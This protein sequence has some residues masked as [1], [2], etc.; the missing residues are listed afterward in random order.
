[1]LALN[2]FNKGRVLQVALGGGEPTLHPA[3]PL[4][5]KETYDRGIV[6]NLTTNGKKMLPRVI[7]AIS[8]YCGA[9]AFSVEDLGQSFYQRRGFKIKKLFKL[10]TSLISI[11][12]KVVFHITV[13]RSNFKKLPKIVEELADLKPY[14]I[15]FLVYKPVGRGQ[16]SESLVTI[17]PKKLHEKIRMALQ[18]LQVRT[19]V[20]FDGCFAPALSL[21]SLVSRYHAY[22]GC[23]ATRTSANVTPTLDVRP[24]SF[25]N[26]VAGNLNNKTLIDIWNG[27]A[28]ENFRFHMQKHMSACFHCILIK[29]CLAGCPQMKLVPCTLQASL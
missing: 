1:L 29:Q 2:E 23:T 7:N 10:A 11:G 26:Q 28:F 15:V 22:E 13:S 4:I 27:D 20:G 3:L 19:N 17:D 5:L 6:P 8:N 9:I 21:L 16:F 18:I 12:V 14:G 25:L 24:C